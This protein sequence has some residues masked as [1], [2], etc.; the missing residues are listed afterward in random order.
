[1]KYVLNYVRTDMA[2]PQPDIP[3]VHVGA[4]LP[5]ELRRTVFL[6]GGVGRECGLGYLP[7]LAG[8]ERRL[9]AISKG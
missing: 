3:R 2:R 1:M 6:H 4:D 9:S 7:N 5:F 8:T